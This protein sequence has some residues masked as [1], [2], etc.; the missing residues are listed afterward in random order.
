MY[1]LFEEVRVLDLTNVLAGPFCTYHLASLGAKVIKI[2]RPG[3]GDLARKLGADPSLNAKLMGT[4]FIAQNAYKKSIVLNLKDKEGKEI[5]LKLSK[6]ADVI[7]ENFRTGVVDRLGIGYKDVKKINPLII[8]CSISG[9]GKNSPYANRP[10]YDQTIQGMS[11]VMSLNG[12]PELNPL[13]CGFPICD[14]VGGLTATMAIASALYYRE[15]KK[16]GLYIDISL[17]DSTLPMLAWVVSNYLI[18][19]QRPVLFGNDNFTAAP[20]GMFRTK[21]GY[22]NISANEDKQ[23]IELCKVIGLKK[24]IK[25]ERFNDREK[26]KKNRKVLNKILNDV[27]STQPT[28]YWVEEL[29]K[30]GVP[31]GEIFSIEKVLELEHVKV[32]DMLLDLNVHRVY[33]K[34]KILNIAPRFLDVETVPPKSPPTLGEH[35]REI[36]HELGYSEKEIESYCQ[37]YS[38]C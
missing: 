10:A 7:V 26:R 32:R 33:R 37:R 14:T 31:C 25:D 9:F 18:G 34:T 4:S 24:L 17:L 30:N 38:I 11:G 13:R 20:S 15:K 12:T 27:L 8:Y 5:F 22:I 3:S 28:A 2:E 16:R 36:L 29:I 23:W 6:N 19:G 35:T 1:K 21:D